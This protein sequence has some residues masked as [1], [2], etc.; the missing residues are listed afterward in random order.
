VLAAILGKFLV[1]LRGDFFAKQD[2]GVILN[3]LL[4]MY[5]S[6]DDCMS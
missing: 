2:F 3:A 1:N 4:F 6:I 5:L